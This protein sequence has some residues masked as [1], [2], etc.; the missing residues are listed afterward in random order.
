M[1]LTGNAAACYV[2]HLFEEFGGAEMPKEKE[3]VV[4][5]TSAVLYA[6]KS[7]L[8]LVVAAKTG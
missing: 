8:S 7:I 1:Q 5:E 2:T 3:K 4:K 6:G